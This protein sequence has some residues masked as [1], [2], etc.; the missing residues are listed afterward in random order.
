MKRFSHSAQFKRSHSLKLKSLA[1]TETVDVAV[2]C[3]RVYLAIH[4]VAAMMSWTVRLVT[5]CSL[6]VGMAKMSLRRRVNVN[7]VKIMPWSDSLDYKL[8]HLS[9]MKPSTS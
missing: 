7:P 8:S 5:P 4:M 3:R 6:T 2:R 9:R 1:E